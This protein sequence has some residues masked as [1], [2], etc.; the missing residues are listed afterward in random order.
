MRGV[1]VSDDKPG[2]SLRHDVVLVDLRARRAERQSAT[3]PRPRRRALAPSALEVCVVSARAV[4]IVSPSNDVCGRSPKP[5]PAGRG[6]EW[7][8]RRRRERPRRR[9]LG[10]PLLL[11]LRPVA[12]RLEAGAEGARSMPS[13]PVVAARLPSR[14]SA[15]RIAPTISPRTS[16]GSRKR[17]SDLAGCTLTSTSAGSSPIDNTATA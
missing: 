15:S 9:G 1:L 10:A 3:A 2:F 5:L 14:A 8:S 7:G 13:A 4:G 17:T 6:G 11:R 12:V 16:C